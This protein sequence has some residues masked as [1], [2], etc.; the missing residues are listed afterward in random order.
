MRTAVDLFCGAAG[1]WSL[2]L[3]A[4][5]FQTIAACEADR[6]RRHVYRKIWG[7]PVHHDARKMTGDWVREKTGSDRPFLVCGSPP[8]THISSANVHGRG[9]DGDGLFF[10]AVRIVSELRP[11]W[12]AFEN[13]DRLPARGLDRVADALE[14]E[15]YTVWPL[16]LGAGNAGA[17][18]RRRRT[19]LLAH[20]QDQQ[21]WPPRQS[22]RLSGVDVD[23]HTD[24]KSSIDSDGKVAGV[25][26]H[27]PP[28]ANSAGL[29]IE[30]GR[31]CW[32]D[33]TDAP[34]SLDPSAGL[35][36]VGTA[37]LGRHLRAYARLP[38]RMAEFCRRAY[39]DSFPPILATIIGNAIKEVEQ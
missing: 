28:D 4:A 12:V 17:T 22:R 9:V 26:G 29:R 11:D 31:R 8:C 14:Q 27:L 5:G 34:I 37:S 13:S 16:I 18:H 30:Q 7:V 38:N 20:M 32:Q 19:F 25:V 15:N 3:H 33:G 24:R 36:P 39:G 23:A 6:L 21:T 2:G 35:G 10:E 1:A